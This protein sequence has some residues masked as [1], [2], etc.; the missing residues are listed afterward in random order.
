MN[1]N[2]VEEL[3]SGIGVYRND[4]LFNLGTT[5]RKGRRDVSFGPVEGPI[6]SLPLVIVS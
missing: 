2:G 5:E 6:E 4:F 3:G 1:E